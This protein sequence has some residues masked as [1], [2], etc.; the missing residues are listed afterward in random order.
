M[1][2]RKGPK[3]WTGKAWACLCNDCLDINGGPRIEYAKR[4]TTPGY[5]PVRVTITP[6]VRPRRPATPGMTREGIE[7]TVDQMA[8]MVLILKQAVKELL[9]VNE[10][11][12][13]LLTSGALGEIKNLVGQLESDATR[14]ESGSK[15]VRDGR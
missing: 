9:P 10:A 5:V 4:D 12:F 15:G 6:L 1:S 8:R 13:F 2:Q 7:Q 3:R 11:Q 14:R